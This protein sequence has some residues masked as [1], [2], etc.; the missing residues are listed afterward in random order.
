MYDFDQNVTGVIVISNLK[1]QQ[2]L[3]KLNEDTKHSLWNFFDS[4]PVT[5]DDVLSDIFFV[6]KDKQ[7]DVEI[8][9]KQE[10]MENYPEDSW[11]YKLVNRDVIKRVNVVENDNS[12]T[13]NYNG[14]SFGHF[15]VGDYREELID[16][17]NKIVSQEC[18]INILQT[19]IVD[20]YGEFDNEL[21]YYF[22]DENR[23]QE[24]VNQ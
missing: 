9:L 7:S 18:E 15:L 20:G 11:E 16:F 24:V 6:N 22:S 21:S 23:F 4:R 17:V 5:K 3:D 1:L 13:I 2:E 10:I 19:L 8:R 14:W 12:I